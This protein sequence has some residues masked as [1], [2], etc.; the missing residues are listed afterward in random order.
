MGLVGPLGRKLYYRPASLRTVIYGISRIYSS[1]IPCKGTSK[2]T[3]SSFWDRKPDASQDKLSDDPGYCLP[4]QRN[5][6]MEL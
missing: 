1:R 4:E 3:F 5:A 6:L 2:G